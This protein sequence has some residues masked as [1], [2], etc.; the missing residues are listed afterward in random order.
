LNETDVYREFRPPPS[1]RGS[2]ACLWRRRGD[3]STVRV[4]PD[5]CA[6]IVWRPGHGA[7]VVGPDTG[8]W[9]SRAEPGEVLFGAR[10]LPGAGGAALGMPLSELR[11]RSVSLHELGLDPREQLG[12]GTEPRDVPWLLAATMSRLIARGPADRAV[13]AAVVCLLDP[14]QRVEQLAGAL[15]FSERQLRRRFQAS[16]GYGPKTAQRVLRLRRF[17][18]DPDGDLARSALSAGYSDQAHLTR[19]CAR[20][21]GLGPA[22]FRRHLTPRAA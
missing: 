1:L 14:S 16:V 6:D 5:A 10:F 15:G 12:A 18:A 2:V 3:G 13:Q 8:P 7:V 22:Q 4:V 11:D 21:T 9:L 19:E 20:L 17:A